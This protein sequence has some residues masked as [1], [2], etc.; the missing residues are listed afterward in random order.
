MST[1]GSGVRDT[2][3]I[4]SLTG[5][6]WSY[7]KGTDGSPSGKGYTMDYSPTAA[8][9]AAMPTSLAGLRA[10][11]ITRWKDQAEASAKAVQNT[12]RPTPVPLPVL[13]SDNDIVF[14]EATYLLWNPLVGPTLR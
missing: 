1:Q 7:Q 6:M 9:F 2:S 13:Q 4:D 12:G 11:L 3:V 5:D 10:A 14:Q 8:Q